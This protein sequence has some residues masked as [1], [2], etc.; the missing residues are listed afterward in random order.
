MSAASDRKAMRQILPAYSLLTIPQLALFLGCGE[1]VAREMV[2][3]STIPSVRVGKRR[4]VDPIDA[5]VHV[6]AD[7][8]GI[9]AGEYWRIHGEATVDHVKRYVV[10]IRKMIAA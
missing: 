9:T 4:H 6:L 8:E 10:R 2:D 1:D 7:R 5:A 3:D